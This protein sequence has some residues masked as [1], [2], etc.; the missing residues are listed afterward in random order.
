ATFSWAANADG[1]GTIDNNNVGD[2]HP[3]VVVDYG[4]GTKQIVQVDLTIKS[5]DNNNEGNLEV[6]QKAPITTH[7]SDS[8]VKVPEFSDPAWIKDNIKLPGNDDSST[9]VDH[10]TWA[11]AQPDTVGDG[12]EIEAVAHYKDGSTSAPFKLAVNVLGAKKTDTPTVITAGDN[13]TASQAEAA[14]DPTENAKIIAKYP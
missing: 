1:T 5:K 3:Y 9:K 13:L 10:L 7:V 4:D 11:E 12:Q 8:E 2:S 6:A 14:L